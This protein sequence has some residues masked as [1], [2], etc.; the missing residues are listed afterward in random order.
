M[1]YNE[2]GTLKAD[3]RPDTPR[4]LPAWAM[5]EYRAG[6]DALIAEVAAAIGNVIVIE[7]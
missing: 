5:D 2:G 4:N 1:T 3:W 6:R 7:L